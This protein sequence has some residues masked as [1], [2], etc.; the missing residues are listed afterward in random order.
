DTANKRK[1]ALFQ[2]S[3]LDRS[4]TWIESCSSFA[5]IV[6]CDVDYETLSHTTDPFAQLADAAI[7]TT[8][9][10]RLFAFTMLA[11]VRKIALFISLFCFFLLLPFHH[12]SP[13]FK[14]LCHHRR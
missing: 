11:E 6:T 9:H 1:Q 13:P 8:F 12:L 4:A 3:P 5:A 7:N 2:H 10:I 14:G